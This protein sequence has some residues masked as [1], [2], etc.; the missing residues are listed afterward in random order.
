MEC[1]CLRFAEIPQTTKL[2][3]SYTENFAA[4]K[5][6]YG[7]APDEA[8]V[9]AVAKEALLEADTRAAVLDV[10]REQNRWLGSDAET[11]KSIDRLAKGAVAIVTGQQVGLFSGP[12]YSFYKALDAIRWAKKLTRAGVDA[13]PIFWLATED[14]DLAEANE[15]FFGERYGVARL[16]APLDK[17]NEGRAVGRIALGSAIDAVVEHAIHLLEGPG[18][19]EIAEALKV[20]YARGE[21]FG[22]AFGKLFARVFKGRGL[23]LLDPLHKRLH[24]LARPIYR[25]AMEDA[26]AI[27]NDLVTRGKKL[28]RDGFHAQVK[29]TQQS[30]L[31][32]LDVDGKREAVR[33]RN[34]GFVAGNLR[35]SADELL[36]K[37]DEEPGA[38]S[39]GVLL[40]PVLQDAILPTAAYVGGPAEVA[41]MAQAEVVYRRVIGRMPA[42][43]P[44]ASFTLLEPAV[45]RALKKYGLTIRDVLG[46]R[47]GLRR[48]MEAEYLPRGLKARFARDEKALR[49][50]LA[51]YG[52]ALGML[53]KTLVGARETAERKMF[54]QFEKLQRKAGRAENIRTG[55]LDRHELEIVS[56]LYPRHGLQERTLC[57]LPFL[58][59]CGMELLERLESAMEKPCPGHRLLAL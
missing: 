11:E 18:K 41:Y 6:F 59:R 19:R 44:R 28:T 51:G 13:V 1:D 52:K 50:M 9:R 10:L 8:E 54:Y 42:I 31:L 49:K 24:E 20:S 14:H 48:K 30:T 40:R 26:E 27:G 15:V 16:E 22:S 45:A 53:D 3:A 17:Q 43:L 5:Q 39:A 32:F 23:I 7:H 29:V 38:L 25:K 34:G 57:L 56:A 46:G 4:V 36:R 55:I 37:I 2:F 58:A 12:A 21:T 35:L 33:R 47:Q